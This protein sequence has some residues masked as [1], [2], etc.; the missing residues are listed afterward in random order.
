[1]KKLI[2]LLA[3]ASLYIIALSTVISCTVTP[4]QK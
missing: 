1:M 2:T 3:S 4:Q